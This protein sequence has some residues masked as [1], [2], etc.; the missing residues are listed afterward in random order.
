MNKQL[1]EVNISSSIR[2]H[3][4]S[5]QLSYKPSRRTTA[6]RRKSQHELAEKLFELL[7]STVH[8]GDIR[9]GI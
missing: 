7:V 3:V 8:E 2:T 1:I 5:A 6:R 4:Q 9:F